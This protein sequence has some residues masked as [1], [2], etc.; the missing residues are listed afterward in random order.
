MR[1]F[2]IDGLIDKEKTIKIMTQ[3]STDAEV[4]NLFMN[5]TNDYIMDEESFIRMLRD[6]RILSKQDLR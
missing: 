6:C 1:S 5:Y 4:Y 2:S 3:K